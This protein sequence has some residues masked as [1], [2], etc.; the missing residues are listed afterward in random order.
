M[1]TLWIAGFDHLLPKARQ[2]ENV[3]FFYRRTIRWLVGCVN[4]FNQYC[5]P[6]E[7]VIAPSILCLSA[8]I[9]S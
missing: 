9:S 3:L 1:D 8:I 6:I 7:V 4:A 2:A 5:M